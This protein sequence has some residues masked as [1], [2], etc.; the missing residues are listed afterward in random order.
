MSVET[1]KNRDVFLKFCFMHFLIHILKVLGIDE[2]ITEILSIEEITFEKLPKIKIFD[3]FLDF[4]VLTKS[5]KIMIFEFK[6]GPLRKSDLKQAYEYFDRIHCKKKSDVKLVIIV[7]SKIGKIKAYTHFDVTYHPQIIKTKTINKQ[8]DLSIIRDKLSN[9]KKLTDLECSLLIALPLFELKESE[10]E[11]TEEICTY[12]TDKKHC[13]PDDIFDEIVVEMYLNI[14][15]Y[16]DDEKQ[17][18]LMEMIDMV[19]SYNGLISQ[20]RNEGRN[21]G[22]KEVINDLL[23]NFPIDVVAVLLSKKKSEIEEILKK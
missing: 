22:K 14:V 5:G 21:N 6:K 13:I 20:I 17:D 4:Q 9:N 12:I 1:V 8:K 11:I 16:I 2:E 3:N 19:E 7:L 23:K 15:E 18:E 10:S